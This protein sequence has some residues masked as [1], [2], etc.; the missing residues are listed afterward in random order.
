MTNHVIS[1]MSNNLDANTIDADE[2]QWRTVKKKKTN[3]GGQPTLV[4]VAS[5]RL[6][7]RGDPCPVTRGRRWRPAYLTYC[8]ADL[9]QAFVTEDDL[10]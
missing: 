2:N 9:L 10:F 4:N 6:Y 3:N 7:K 5:G 8:Q 1:I